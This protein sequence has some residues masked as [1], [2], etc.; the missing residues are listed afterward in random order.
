M[1]LLIIT[2]NKDKWKVAKELL[3][4]YNIPLDQ[5][6]IETPEIQSMNVIEIAEYSARFAQKS[7]GEEVLKTDVGYY[8]TALNG[9]PGPFAKY[10]NQGLGVQDL[11]NLMK[12]Y[13]NRE[14]TIRECLAFCNKKGQ[15][16]SF[17]SEIKATLSD[18]P[19]G[20]GSTLDQMTILPGFV[21]PQG[22][23]P[24]EEIFSFWNKN[25]Q[26]YHDFGKYFTS[27]RSGDESS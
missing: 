21:L 27:K 6:K 3:S 9:F 10:F 7:L 19:Q 13:A 20:T 24:K 2:G 18:S 5:V 14:I 12:P 1:S 11:T 26:H 4:Q 23:T 25:Q 17:I 8:I 22:A 15:V 16:K